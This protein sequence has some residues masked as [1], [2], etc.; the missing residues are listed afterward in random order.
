MM[1][2][3]P[4]NVRGRRCLKFT[5]SEESMEACH[6]SVHLVKDDSRGEQKIQTFVVPQQKETIAWWDEGSPSKR[7]LIPKS[8]RSRVSLLG[9]VLQRQG[10]KQGGVPLDPM[11]DGQDVPE[12]CESDHDR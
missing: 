2:G 6:T 10:S 9:R 8:P 11:M 5:F 7:P 4:E 3:S 1:D 12:R